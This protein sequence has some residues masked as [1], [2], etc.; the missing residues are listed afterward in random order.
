ME[1]ISYPY[2]SVSYINRIFLPETMRNI[3][4]NL[5]KDYEINL[6]TS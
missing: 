2:K 6:Q 3:V 5:N 1:L 4:S